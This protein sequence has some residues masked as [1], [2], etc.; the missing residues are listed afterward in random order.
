MSALPLVWPFFP[1]WEQQVSER[2]QWLTDV[3]VSP[4]GG[5]Q[6]RSLR[7]SPRRSFEAEVIAAH[8]ERA[9]FDLAVAQRGGMVWVLPIW[10]DVQWLD[11]QLSADDL[12]VPCR[13]DGF[14]F[15]AGGQAVLRGE[16]A[17]DTELLQIESVGPDGLVLAQPP[18]GDWPAG[19]ALYPARLARLAEQPSV[20]RMT[21]EL[22][23]ASVSF[24]LAEPSDWSAAAPVQVYRGS[25]VFLARPEESNALKHGT[26]RL[27]QVLDNSISLPAVTDTAG[28]GFLLLAYR[29]QLEGR[30]EHTAWRSLMYALR[31]RAGSVWVST[32][33]A[34][35]VVMAK[36]TASTLAVRRCGYARLGL[37]TMGKQDLHIQLHDGTELLRR[38]VNASE[39]GDIEYLALDTPLPKAYGP[40]D[41]GRISYLALC[42][43]TDDQLELKHQT[44]ADGLASAEVTWRGV[45][46]DLESVA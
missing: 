38:V 42:R 35:L 41:V 24:D 33:A 20:T 15:V 34:D 28:R 4:Q 16:T 11:A 22:L 32:Y 1:N 19:S 29:W 27:L 25:P 14:D 36:G 2:L 26:E 7:I 37:G 31:G 6:R 10:P 45:R 17:F 9:M 8:Q 5:E 21:D 13:T 40:E 39:A 43:L 30:H 23:K 12:S 18:V 44:D 46:D 3:L